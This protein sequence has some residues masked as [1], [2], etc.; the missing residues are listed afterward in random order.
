M[1]GAFRPIPITHLSYA[2]FWGCN[3]T[4]GESFRWKRGFSDFITKTT[5]NLLFFSWGL[6][7]ACVKCAI[8]RY[9]LPF[10]TITPA[11]PSPPPTGDNRK[12]GPLCGFVCAQTTPIVMQTWWFRW[13]FLI[14]VKWLI[15]FA[16]RVI[17]GWIGINI[18][19]SECIRSVA[20]L[21]FCVSQINPDILNSIQQFSPDIFHIH[22]CPTVFSFLERFLSFNMHLRTVTYNSAPHFLQWLSQPRD[23]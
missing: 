19:P 12:P 23:N 14:L 21:K 20:E 4:G 18:Q 5:S 16:E 17:L 22:F 10:F 7:K 8:K 3:K 13:H 11:V 1:H 2:F 15:I 9:A 6:A